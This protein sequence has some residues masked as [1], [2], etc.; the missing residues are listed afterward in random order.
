MRRKMCGLEEAI[1]LIANKLSMPELKDLM[2]EQEGDTYSS[3]DRDNSRQEIAPASTSSSHAPPTWEVVMDPESGPAAIP[4]SCVST[5]PHVRN[6]SLLPNGDRSHL[7]LITRGVVSLE[8][9]ESFFS[10]YSQR[11]DHFIYRILIDHDSLSSVRASSPLLTAAVCAVGALHKSSAEFD[12]C[13]EEFINLSAAQVFSKKNTADD[14]RALCIGAFWLS[15]V[16]WTLV[17]LGK[18]LQSFAKSVSGVLTLFQAVRIATEIELHRCISKMPHEKRECYVRTRLWYLVYVC[19]HHF[20]IAYGKPPMTHDFEALNPTASFLDSKYATEDDASLVSQVE[21][22]SI[23]TRVFETFGVDTDAPVSDRLVPQLRRFGIALDTW[24][25]NWNERFNVN[26]H[27]G[28]YPREG[29]GL[30]FHFAKLYLCSH[31]FRGLQRT[32]N[33][34]FDMA[35]EMEEFATT[36]V[37]SAISILR[38]IV[39]DSEIKSHLNGLPLYFDTMIAFAVVFLLKM[40]TRDSGN[41]RIDRHEVLSL[42]GQLD[43]VLKSLKPSF[44]RR[45]LLFSI[46][47]SIEKLLDRCLQPANQETLLRPSAHMHPGSETLEQAQDW[48]T[49]PSETFFINNYDFLGSQDLLNGFDFDISILGFD[50]MQH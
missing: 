1:G 18:H 20:S 33:T 30:Y 34:L 29:V 7:D 22:W 42:V 2:K 35:S 19:D 8:N 21:I 48:M 9:A 16:S 39:S 47:T 10:V 36:A 27:V 26:S 38:I 23:G 5:I 45:H 3:T 43:G 15:D 37:L 4:A 46:A 14:V 24:R 41:V 32:T 50:Q 31:V 13:Y 11:L 25:A 17:G 44:H 49:S 40:A 28:N 12:A 6:P